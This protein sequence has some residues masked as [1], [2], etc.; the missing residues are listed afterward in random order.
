[1]S[2]PG[3]KFVVSFSPVAAGAPAKKKRWT[4]TQNLSKIWDVFSAWSSIPPYTSRPLG[5]SNWQVQWRPPTSCRFFISTIQLLFRTFDDDCVSQG[6]SEATDVEQQHESGNTAGPSQPCHANNHPSINES[7]WM[8]Q[9][10]CHF[11][12]GGGGSG[13]SY[14]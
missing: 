6:F 7:G 2:R 8:H 9:P 4:K 3:T 13:Q 12:C 1:M 5:S 14:S 11:G 10:L